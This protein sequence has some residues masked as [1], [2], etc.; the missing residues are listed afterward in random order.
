MAAAD[1]GNTEYRVFDI[2]I[3]M[4]EEEESFY[5]GGF[6]V[7]VT[8]PEYVTG[9]DFHLYHLHDGLVQEI[10]ALTI[11]GTQPDEYG[12]ERHFCIL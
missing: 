10:N 12:V 7:S 9:R 5:A 4:T 1:E 2:S 6:D 8:L 3:A 11:D